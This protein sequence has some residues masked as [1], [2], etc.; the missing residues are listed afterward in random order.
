[1]WTEFLA[2]ILPILPILCLQKCSQ[3]KVL[4]NI[5]SCDR[6]GLREPSR[7]NG[8][9]L[10]KG[11]S[12]PVSMAFSASPVQR[13]GFPRMSKKRRAKEWRGYPQNGGLPRPPPCT[14]MYGRFRRCL[15]APCGLGTDTRKTLGQ[16]RRVFSAI[17]SRQDQPPARSMKIR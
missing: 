15:A 12:A 1:L 10:S 13:A 8:N 9:S 2:A 11:R 16:G 6:Q 14:T 3:P 4:A 7:F 5:M 17:R